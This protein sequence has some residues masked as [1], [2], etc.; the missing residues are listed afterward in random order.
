MSVWHHDVM[1]LLGIWPPPCPPPLPPTPN[2]LNLPTPMIYDYFIIWPSR[3]TSALNL[4][5]Q[6]FQMNNCA[7]FW[8]PCINIEVMAQTSSIY[9]HFII[10]PSS[11]ISTFDLPEQMFQMALLLLK[12]N[13]CAK[14][15]L[16]SMHKCRSYGPDKSER[17]HNTRTHIHQTEIVT[18]M[19]CSPQAGLTKIAWIRKIQLFLQLIPHL[20]VWLCYKHIALAI[21]NLLYI[22]VIP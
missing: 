1:C 15:I 10:W 22:T 19:S 17:M 2:I 14:F 3:A 12:E 13:N 6:M 21:D 8:H 9:N 11:V 5:E 20:I 7:K 16:K 4:P 18:T